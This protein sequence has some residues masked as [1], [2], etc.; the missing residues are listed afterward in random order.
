MALFLT[1]FGIGFLLL[2][3]ELGHFMAARFAGVR[4]EVF[5]I[6]MGPRLFGFRRKGT[7]FRIAMLPIGGY[8]KM[9]G[10]D[11]RG[12]GRPDDLL[13]KP[14]RHRFLI[15]SGGIL[16]NFA[17][18]LLLVPLLF[19]IGVPMQTPVAGEVVSGSPGWEAGVREGDRLLELDG[20][21]VHAFSGF[22]TQVALSSVSETMPLRVRG[23][24]GSERALTLLPEYEAA[25]GLPQAGVQPSTDVVAVAG[26]P[27]TSAGVPA[28]ARLVSIDGVATDQP[29]EWRILLTEAVLAGAS[30]DLVFESADG[31]LP[32]TLVPV[33]AAGSERHQIG[34][35]VANDLVARVLE[36]SGSGLEAGD[37][38]LS[39]DGQPVRSANTILALAIGNQRMPLLE[40][41]RGT[42]RVQVQ[43]Q[44]DAADFAASVHLQADP[45]AV[46][47]LVRPD[48]PAWQAGLRSGDEVVR[49]GNQVVESF[50]DVRV[51]IGALDDDGAPAEKVLD[52]FVLRQGA[53]LEFPLE[54]QKKAGL[55]YGLAFSVQQEV[56]QRSNVLAAL[57]TGLRS[58]QAMV[59]D[60]FLSFQRILT[61]QIS[62]KN[63]GGIITIGRSTHRIAE[64][65]LIQF[66]FFLC[67]ISIHLG[68]LNLLPI[69]GL[70]GGHLLF[71]LVEGVRGRPVS[72]KVQIWFNLGG[73]V[74]VMGLIVFVTYLD[75]Q[76]LVP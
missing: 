61:G 76:R 8:V 41:L 72:E 21:K 59:Q 74:L 32:V 39:A 65:G 24:D 37:R 66:L 18:A 51:R 62:H 26:S 43:P 63:L 67:M 9:A 70:D 10:E 33:A 7:D 27:A 16:M 28:G 23:A 53:M 49:I 34:V 68:V 3:H 14:V 1:I 30:M 6:G 2:I 46:R 75:I 13:S 73:F 69:P 45:R 47:L 57:S 48:G 55:D 42:E 29:L 38:I 4:V 22:R 35:F 52:F 11:G 71:L 5:A 56:V 40:V 64:A 12:G 36:G 17:F 60:A 31:L 15:F 44:G 50:A 25:L 19:R 20:R 54:P 58:A